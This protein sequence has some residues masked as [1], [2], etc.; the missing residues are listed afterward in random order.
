MNI[1]GKNILI[2]GDYTIEQVDV[3]LTFNSFDGCESYFR[4][5]GFIPPVYCH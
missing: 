5:T 1:F 4:T 3:N 2:A